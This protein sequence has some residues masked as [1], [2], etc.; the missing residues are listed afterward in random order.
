MVYA[1]NFCIIPLIEQQ[2][3]AK[4]TLLMR[5]MISTLYKGTS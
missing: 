1:Y 2:G 4:V 5:F 3:A